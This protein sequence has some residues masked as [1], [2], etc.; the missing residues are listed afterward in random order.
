MF[1]TVVYIR[2]VTSTE[3]CHG[4]YV[5]LHLNYVNI[6]TTVIFK[7]LEKVLSLTTLITSAA[8]LT[9]TGL[10]GIHFST[11]KT[12]LKG[13]RGKFFISSF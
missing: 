13:N 7:T 12:S 3:N 10:C 8:S 1:E 2:F 11:P 9:R 4:E 6:L 5:C